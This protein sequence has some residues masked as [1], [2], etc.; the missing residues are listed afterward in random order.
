[1]QPTQGQSENST[2]YFYIFVH[3]GSHNRKEAFPY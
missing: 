2:Q 3:A 1:M